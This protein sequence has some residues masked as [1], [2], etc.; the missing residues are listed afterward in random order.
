M[1][2]RLRSSIL[3]MV[4]AMLA[5]EARSA[6]ETFEVLKVGS[7]TYT[8]VTVLNKTAAYVFITHTGGSINLK[9]KDLAAEDLQ[10]LGYTPAGPAKPGALARP[11]KRQRVREQGGERQRSRL[12]PF[13]DL[14]GKVRGQKGQRQNAT[15]IDRTKLCFSGKCGN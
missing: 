13:Q 10:K 2:K 12:P 9:V 5:G 7:L 1:I 15:G 6:D 4:L 14:L 3:V 8:N 11:V